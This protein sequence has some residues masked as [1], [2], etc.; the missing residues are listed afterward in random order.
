MF[1]SGFGRFVCLGIALVCGSLCAQTD[2]IDDFEPAIRPRRPRADQTRTP[3]SLDGGASINPFL[4]SEIQDETLGL[5]DADRDAYFRILM[6]TQKLPDEELRLLAREFRE[7]RHAASPK[8]RKQPKA[9]FPTFVDLFQHPAD[10]RGRPVTLHGYFRRLI[11]YSAGE[12]T[13]GFETIYEG[14]LYPDAGQGNPAVVIFTEKP[15]GLPI[16]GDITEEVSVTGYFFK[17]YGYQAQDAPRKAPLLLA[18]SVR[19]Q[20]RKAIAQWTPSPQFYG[21]ITAGILFLGVMIAIGVR[22]S[23]IQRDQERRAR[24]SPYDVFVP[25]ESVTGQPVSFPSRNGVPT[26]PHH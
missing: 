17:M 19:W 12:N 16:G 8:Y 1:P 6:L 4:L 3:I 23:K 13:Q 11:S 20:P 18:N 25:P 7:D 21:L 15:D 10:Y 9:K 14:W 26:E 22:E 2:S 5:T 24:Q